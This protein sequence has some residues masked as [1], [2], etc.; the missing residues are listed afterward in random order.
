MLTRRKFLKTIG[1]VI[2]LT[3]TP[4][5][6]KGCAAGFPTYRGEFDGTKIRIAKAEALALATENS[7]MMVRASNLP[8]PIV[9]RNL[10]GKG[11]IALSTICTHA[12]CEVRV[13]L[14]SFECPCHGSAYAVDGA[15]E[16]GPAS[17]PLQ[18]FIVED[19]PEA[20]IIRVKS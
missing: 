12:G 17:R 16:E 6:L 5:F 3:T 20:I 11:L 8:I 14:N 7:V 10:A 15:V 9:M 4:L 1:G 19:T 2:T 18:R 13:L